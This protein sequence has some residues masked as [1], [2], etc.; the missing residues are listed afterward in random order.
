MLHVVSRRDCFM[1]Q[2]RE[3]TADIVVLSVSDVISARET[4]L[5]HPGTS[6]PAPSPGENRM[7][8][9]IRRAGPVLRSAAGQGQRVFVA[10]ME[11]AP[12]SR[13]KSPAERCGP[14]LS[15][16]APR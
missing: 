9:G 13:A 11:A 3:I 2:S 10:A 7:D 5:C 8:D 16:T 14:L 15:V 12:G 4:L 6:P 1:N